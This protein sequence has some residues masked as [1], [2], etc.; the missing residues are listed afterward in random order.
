MLRVAVGSDHAG[1]RLKEELKAFLAAEGYEVGDFGTASEE[2]VDYPDYALA[3]ARSVA[4]REYDRGLLICGTG[5]G[6]SIVAN[7][8][9]GVRAA[10]TAEPLSARL[11]RQHNDANV[12][13]L[14]ARIIGPDLAQECLRV[15]LTSDFQGGRHR[16]RVDKITAEEERPFVD[17]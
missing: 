11:A 3:V 9:R 6:M 5:I 14:G 13:C 2:S 10:L 17:R 7:K 1:Y 12:I 16:R 4:K 8:V 15:F